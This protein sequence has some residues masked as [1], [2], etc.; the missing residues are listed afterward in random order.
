M[1]INAIW[2]PQPLLALSNTATFVLGGVILLVLIIFAYLVANVLRLWVQ[3]QLT[4]ADVGLLTLITMP[5]RKVQPAVIVNNKI[6][7]VK[8][9][10]ST[11]TTNDLES[12]YLAGGRLE[13]V[14]KAM[15]A[16]DRA[17]IDLDWKTS[18]AID[19]AGRDVL[20]AVQTSVNPKVIDCPGVSSGKETIDAVAADGIQLKARARVTVRTNIR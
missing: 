5:F 4:R 8:A 19:L 16:A 1:M 15:I 6:T 10:L 2:S 7:L 9:G 20:E 12:H 3:A 14:C 11:V 18:T 13:K 17:N